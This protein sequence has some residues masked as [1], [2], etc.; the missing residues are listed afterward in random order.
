MIPTNRK[1]DVMKALL[2]TLVIALPSIPAFAESACTP[3][4]ITLGQYRIRAEYGWFI[5]VGDLTNNC[6][7]ATGVELTVTLYGADNAVLDTNN[8]WP[9]S[10][11]N[12]PPKSRYPV[13]TMLTYQHGVKRF[14]VRVQSVKRW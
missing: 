11:S 9:A 7:E 3:Q 10:T 5:I 13:K 4:D 14:D 1:D 6:V 8:F 2:L 12:I